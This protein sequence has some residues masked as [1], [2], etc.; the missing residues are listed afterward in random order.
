MLQKVC[1]LIKGPRLNIS[2][3]TFDIY[4]FVIAINLYYKFYHKIRGLAMFK[5][6]HDERLEEAHIDKIA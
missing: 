2:E 1:A 4:G 6:N 5:A 3:V